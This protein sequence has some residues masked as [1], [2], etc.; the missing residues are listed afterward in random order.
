ML[1]L[2]FAEFLEK[3]MGEILTLTVLIHSHRDC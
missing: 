1:G 2:I 3:G